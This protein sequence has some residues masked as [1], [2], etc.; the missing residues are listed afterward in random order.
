[1]IELLITIYYTLIL[2]GM[3]VCGVNV[4]QRIY[5]DSPVSPPL[6]YLLSFGFCAVLISW[7]GFAGFFGM[8]GVVQGSGILFAL[9]AVWNSSRFYKIIRSSYRSEPYASWFVTGILLCACVPKWCYLFGGI[10]NVKDEIRSI[11]LTVA[12]AAND[13]KP[14][15]PF[16]FSLPISYSYYFYQIPAFL[17]A[18][19]SGYRWPSIAL[20][21]TS[22]VAITLF[23]IVFTLYIKAAFPKHNR[24]TV[25][26]GL[27]CITFFGLD[28]FINTAA[29]SEMHIEWWNDFQVTSM[30]SYHHWVYQYLMGL[31]YALAALYALAQYMQAPHR[32]WLYVSAG[33]TAFCLTFAAITGVWLCIVIAL[34]GAFAMPCMR[35]HILAALRCLPTAL[36]ILS[37]IL[38]PQLFTFIERDTLV[39][40]TSP[41]LWFT[42]E[43]IEGASLGAWRNNISILCEELGPLLTSGLLMVPLYGWDA[44]RRRQWFLIALLSMA[45]IIAIGVSV[46]TARWN[47]WFWR[48]SNLF[49]SVI[50]TFGIIWI[51][52]NWRLVMPERLIHAAIAV[53][54]LPGIA[55]YAAESWFR[56]S[57]C[58]IPPDTIQTINSSVDL[59][60]VI[61]MDD[62]FAENDV[63]LG[64]RIVFGNQSTGFSKNYINLDSFLA[65]S[66]HVPLNQTP[67]DTTW[68]GSASPNGFIVSIVKTK[69]RLQ[70]CP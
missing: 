27:L 15:F 17:Y 20:A 30:A 38:L 11:A 4:L 57:S 42:R 64:G 23:Y 41:V 32:H 14:A 58:T 28:I 48:G 44:I 49:L 51:Y 19:V 9:Y 55:N 3:L 50:A 47:D 53:L 69:I 61:I 24:Y 35:G 29:S 26:I 13:L 34:F 45:I 63:L 10:N 18:T 5:P 56:W 43:R 40:W 8:K 62:S 33:C 1:M 22:L 25:V 21:I 59:H 6:Y 70:S 7:L 2:F 37:I 52:E 46:T 12:F 65:D 66:L 16:N 31:S 67:C 54:L 60:G 68:F 36:V 39:E